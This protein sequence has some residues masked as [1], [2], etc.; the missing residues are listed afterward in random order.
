MLHTWSCLSSVVSPVST[1]SYLT[2]MVSHVLLAAPPTL[3]PIKLGL[4]HVIFALTSSKLPIGGASY[5]GRIL[6]DDR[7]L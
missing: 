3:G 1:V 6:L 5:Y 7:P 2:E 4:G